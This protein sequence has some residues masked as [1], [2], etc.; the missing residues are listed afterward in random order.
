MT[1]PVDVVRALAQ[2]LDRG[3]V[4]AALAQCEPDGLVELRGPL[5][6]VAFTTAEAWRAA[7]QR[8][9]ALH[10]GA[11]EDGRRLSVATITG[12]EE[13]WVAVD[14]TARLRHRPS[15]EVRSFV[16]SSFFALASGRI[17]RQRHRV[18]SARP[19]EQ[20]ERP[21]ARQYPARP[22]VGVGA[23]VPVDDRVVLVQRRDE[24]LAGQWTLPGGLLE[25]GE[26]LEQAVARE[27][28]EET[29]LAVTVGPL[30]EVFD[31]ILYDEAKR[32]RYHFVLVDY[33]C[34][35]RQGELRPGSDVTDA[36]LVAPSDLDR[37]WV[38]PKATAVIHRA[39]AL[40]ERAP[41]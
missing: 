3:D 34:W 40:A 14:W 35:P 38:S 7:L 12:V 11:F 29:G 1:D 21:S 37:Y 23:V 28:Q 17:R 2:A 27:I 8:F 26:T 20:V 10:D 19:D 6:E 36:A 13:G 4:E 31:R 9:G 15:G 18:T 30:V 33:L 24:P 39:L 41:H 22:L 32:V 5:G 25:V 16:G